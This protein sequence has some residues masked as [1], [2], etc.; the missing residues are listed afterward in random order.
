MISVQ[1]FC[2]WWEFRVGLLDMTTLART[3]GKVSM[4]VSVRAFCSR[5]GIVHHVEGNGEGFPMEAQPVV[6]RRRTHTPHHTLYGACHQITM[7]GHKVCRGRGRGKD[8]GRVGVIT[9]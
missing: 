4:M 6:H 9:S 7:Y 2:G 3:G 1:A 5:Q 8:R